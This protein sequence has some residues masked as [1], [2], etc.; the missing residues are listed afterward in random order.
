MKRH[1]PTLSLASSP[2]SIR[3]RWY[4]HAIGTATLLCSVSAPAIATDACA[5]AK[6]P[7]ADWQLRMP[8]EVIDGRIYVPVGVN[9]RGPF[10]FAVDTGA[11][12]MGRADTSLVS[13]LGLTVHGQADNSDGVTRAKADVTRLDSLAL[14]GLVH[15][16][17]EVIT[18]DYS[19]NKPATEKFSGILGREFF[20]DGLLVIDYP[21]QTLYFSRTVALA[22]DQPG[23]IG[24]ERAFRI[25]VTIGGVATS[26]NLDTGANVSFV[27]PQ[28]LY[29]QLADTPLQ[30]AGTG[31][32]SNT[33]LET[34]RAQ[35]PGPFRLGGVT[36]A[37]VEVRVS[38]RYPELL[39]GA[40]VLQ[41]MTV[42]IDQRS[43]AIA[44]CQ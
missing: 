43:R 11:S 14:G 20:S 35:L 7:E 36:L 41:Q 33:T 13:A 26:G 3:K 10:R 25:P 42:M 8:F 18:R 22:Q 23:V 37:N 1:F 38:G 17:L 31:T 32:L 44:L 4:R 29:A 30:R 28:S 12:G 40:H 39:V 6:R 16:D 21:K 15:R 5:L 34:G 2:A 19:G 27:L 24:Y 9:G